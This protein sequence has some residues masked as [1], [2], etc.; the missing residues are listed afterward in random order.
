MTNSKQFKKL[1]NF[2]IDEFINQIPKIGSIIGLDLGEK[3]IGIAIS[4]ENRSI[5]IGVK[6]IDRK[7]LITDINIISK[8]IDENNITAIIVGRPLNTYGKPGKKSQSIRRLSEEINKSLKLPLLLWDERY[9]TQ[10]VEKIMITDIN[11]SRNIRKE[12]IDSS[13]A[14]WILEGALKRMKININ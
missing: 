11:L 14:C 3:R 1:I 8:I 2:N 5:V 10:A 12:L 13:A 7:K 4:D 6:H 9:S